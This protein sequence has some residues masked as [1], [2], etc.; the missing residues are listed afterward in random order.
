MVL[1]SR[2]PE[3]NE[4]FDPGS[5]PDLPPFYPWLHPEDSV[6]EAAENKEH[7]AKAAF[8]ITW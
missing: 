6:T 8:F 4:S 2:I 3:K 1:I 7:L 5:A